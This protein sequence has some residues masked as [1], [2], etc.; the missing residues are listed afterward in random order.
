MTDP[1]DFY[2]GL[3][4]ELYAPLR[5][6]TSDPAEYASFIASSGE[7]A[8]E[9][10]CGDGDPLL[11]LRALGLDV[12]GVDSSADMLDRLRASAAARG[13]SVTVHQQ[14]MEDLDLPRRYR[15]IFLAG[16]TFTLLATDDARPARA[17]GDPGAP[18]RRRDRARPA[19]RPCTDTGGPGREPS[20]P[21]ST[22]EGATIRVGVVDEDWDAATRTRRTTLRYER[23]TGA[24]VER[25]D[26]VWLLHWHTPAGFSA[27]AVQAGLVAARTG[28]STATRRSS[29]VADWPT[30]TPGPEAG[31]GPGA[32]ARGA[33]SRGTSRSG[34]PARPGG[35]GAARSRGR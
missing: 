11:D 19:L 10:G 25:V 29:A 32:T 31:G 23:S 4:A 28:P 6:F 12:D 7:P 1:A 14:R 8:L 26:R 34:R 24:G 3:V 5:S 35:P 21:W 30:S 16:A 9:L 33:L 20:D 27:L 18:H 17:A 22:D 15:S 13:L 2:T